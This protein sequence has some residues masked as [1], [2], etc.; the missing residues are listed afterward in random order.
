MGFPSMK[1]AP[2]NRRNGCE[3]G[4][5]DPVAQEHGTASPIA[6]MISKEKNKDKKKAPDDAGAFA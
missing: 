1:L 4:A 3:S 2:V 6:A 5:R